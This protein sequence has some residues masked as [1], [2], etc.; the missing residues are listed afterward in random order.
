MDGFVSNAADVIN[1]CENIAGQIV[2][3][4]VGEDFRAQIIV[5]RRAEFVVV[6]INPINCKFQSAAGVK[7]SG[8]RIGIN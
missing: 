3:E 4:I 5:V 7:T 1:F 6:F 8:A 2:F